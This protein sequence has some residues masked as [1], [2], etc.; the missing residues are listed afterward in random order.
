MIT[1]GSC[2]APEYGRLALGWTATGVFWV[3][4]RGYDGGEYGGVRAVGSVL[5]GSYTK[6][7]VSGSSDWCSQA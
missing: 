4:I 3:I 2:S 6:S 1:V 5:A 7:G